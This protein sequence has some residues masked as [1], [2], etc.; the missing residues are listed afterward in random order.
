MQALSLP[1]MPARLYDPHKTA[2]NALEQAKPTKIDHQEDEFDDLFVAADSISQTKQLAKM[3]YNDENLIE[4]NKLRE[5]RLQTLPLDLL[6]LTT[7]SSSSEPGQ[8]QTSQPPVINKEQK[9]QQ[10]ERQEK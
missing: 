7:A 9:K 2:Y 10:E 6:S 8:K 5:Q 1:T 3:R 4:F